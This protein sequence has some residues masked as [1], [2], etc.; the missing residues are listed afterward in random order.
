MVREIKGKKRNAGGN[1]AS[2]IMHFLVEVS[3]GESPR[4]ARGG[5][6]RVPKIM[7]KC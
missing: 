6:N 1:G 4:S 2:L 5:G 3:N 7:D